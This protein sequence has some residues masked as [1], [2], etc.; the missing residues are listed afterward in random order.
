MSKETDYI[1]MHT[2]TK[3]LMTVNNHFET[4]SSYTITM[5]IK[6]HFMKL[7]TI[8]MQLKELYTLKINP[9]GIQ[10]SNN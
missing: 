10:S 8:I 9:I 4:I 3:R 1:Q 7:M 5:A 6:L 2:Q